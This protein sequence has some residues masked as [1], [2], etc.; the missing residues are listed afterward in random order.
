MPPNSLHTQHLIRCPKNVEHTLI[1]PE[2]FADFIPPNV[3]VTEVR[4]LTLKQQ[5]KPCIWEITITLEGDA[6]V[7][8]DNVKRYYLRSNLDKYKP[9]NTNL[10]PEKKAIRNGDVYWIFEYEIIC[11]CGLSQ[12]F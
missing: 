6:S 3:R 9:R 4:G 5:K 10:L 2:G 11:E 12:V 7:Y 1:N 8:Y